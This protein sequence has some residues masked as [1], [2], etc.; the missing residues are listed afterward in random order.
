MIKKLCN[1]C[2]YPMPNNRNGMCR[3]CK[4]YW[5]KKKRGER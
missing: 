5:L 4:G 1:T 3:K 2:F